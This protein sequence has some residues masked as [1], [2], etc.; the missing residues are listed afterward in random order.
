MSSETKTAAAQ[1][2]VSSRGTS[3]TSI[4]NYMLQPKPVN[5]P[6][7]QSIDNTSI[8]AKTPETSK[9]VKIDKYNRLTQQSIIYYFTTPPN[10]SSSTCTPCRPVKQAV[11][12]TSSP[13]ISLNL[14][15]TIFQHDIAAHKP[16]Q[17]HLPT[18][19]QSSLR[20]FFHPLKRTRSQPIRL[21]PTN[22]P[23][24]ANPT[25]STAS[26]GQP[27]RT[28]L[29]RAVRREL[30]RYTKKNTKT[31]NKIQRYTISMPTYDLFDM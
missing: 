22:T 16:T 13:G 20:E 14:E 11:Q 15:A 24:Y 29:P 27:S 31:K 17:Y 9:N 28:T 4:I 23:A 26:S 7:I 25:Q 3:Q 18:W 6:I 10:S 1:R 2:G 12:R 21:Q 30:L 5:T 19:K 8:L